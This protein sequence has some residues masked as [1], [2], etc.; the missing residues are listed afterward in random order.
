MKSS[1]SIQGEALNTKIEVFKKQVWDYYKKNGR[2]DL[3]WRQPSLNLRSGKKDFNSYYILVSEIM[4][5]QTQVCRVAEKYREFLKA[6]PTVQEL[7]RSDLSTVLRVWSG[8]GYNR[9]GKYLRDAAKTIVEKYN[10]EVPRERSDL[11]SLSGIGPYTASAIRIFAFDL[12]DTFIETNVRAAYIHF[13]CESDSLNENKSI[14]DAQIVPLAIQAAEG[15]DPRKWHW[16]L[17]DYGSHLKKIH[18][19]PSRKSAHYVRQSKFKGSLREV[20]GAI[21]RKLQSSRGLTVRDLPFEKPRINQAF[22][23]LKRD[24]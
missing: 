8:M 13:L 23:G 18:H 17:M 11:R 6:F 20:R 22:S 21:L 10:G 1:R 24:G 4:L 5:Q 14:N 2:H 12:P 9:R 16:A 7:A 3:P 15:Q 19:N